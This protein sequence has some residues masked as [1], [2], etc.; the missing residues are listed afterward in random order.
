MRLCKKPS[1]EQQKD[2]AEKNL[3]ERLALLKAE[4]WPPQRIQ[5]DAKIRQFQAEKRQAIKRLAAIA[6]AVALTAER[7]EIKARKLATPPDPPR[8]R[9]K[10]AP[11]APRK[12]KPKRKPVESEA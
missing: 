2:T 12:T 8:S 9:K 5:R 4:G 6:D 1:I 11:T 3:A 10:A 7:A